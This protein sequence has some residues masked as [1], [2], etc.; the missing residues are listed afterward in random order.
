MK[1]LLTIV[2]VLSMVISLVACS[3]NSESKNG[4][5]TTESTSDTTSSDSSTGSEVPELKGAGNVTLKRLEIGR[6]HV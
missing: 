3:N 6:A 2:L 4:S 5:D 1:K